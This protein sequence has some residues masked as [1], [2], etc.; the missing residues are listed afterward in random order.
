MKAGS[1]LGVNPAGHALLNSF[2]LINLLRVWTDSLLGRHVISLTVKGYLEQEY[3]HQFNSITESVIPSNN[4]DA[5]HRFPL[6]LALSPS[7]EF[8]MVLK[9]YSLSF[10][11][12]RFQLNPNCR[13]KRYFQMKPCK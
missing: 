5:T 2:S 8:R 10:L 7:P 1:C 9:F 11:E 4:F 3:R 13:M 12:I 6:L